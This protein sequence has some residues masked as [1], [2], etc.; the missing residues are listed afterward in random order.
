MIGQFDI[1]VKVDLL[2]SCRHQLQCNYF[3]NCTAVACPNSNDKACQSV[4]TIKIVLQDKRT[5]KDG[6]TSVVY[7]SVELSGRLAI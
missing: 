5:G 6:P 3:W 7:L 4:V 1:P 2:V